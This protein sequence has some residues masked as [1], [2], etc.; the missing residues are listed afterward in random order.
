VPDKSWQGEDR[1]KENLDFEIL[2]RKIDRVYDFLK[3][4]FG[5]VDL[6]GNKVEGKM[7]E[8]LRELKDQVIVQN[9]RIEILEKNNEKLAGS[10]WII[11]ILFTAFIGLGTLIILWIKK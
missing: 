10:A 7:N 8:A 6:A 3:V 4:Q 2:D 9:S 1:R 11:G 5:D